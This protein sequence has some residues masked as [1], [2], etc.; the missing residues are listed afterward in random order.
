MNNIYTRIL[1]FALLLS[2]SLQANLNLVNGVKKYDSFSIQYVYDENKTL[3]I[4]DIVIQKNMQEIPNQFTKGYKYG[5]AWFKIELTNKSKNEEF[6]LYFTESIWS[7]IDLY[8]QTDTGWRI[9]QNGLNIPLEKRTIKDSSPA[10][11]LHIPKDETLTLYIKGET[12]ASQIGQFK[13]FTQEEYFNPSRLRLTDLYTIYA[14]ILFAFILLNLYNFVMTRE[15]IYGL[16]VVY[17]GTYI[18]FISM[19]SGIYINFGFPN[20]TEGLHTLGQ[21]TLLALILFSS[22]FLE[23]KKTYPTMQRLFNYLAVGALIFAIML[24]QNIPYA[25][26]ASNIF[27]CSA[28]LSIVVVAILVLKR[29]FKGA[30]YYL[31]ALMLY[32]PSMTLMA[33]N[34]NAMVANTDITRYSFLAGAFLEI[35]L[36][37]LILTNR[38]KYISKLNGSLKEKTQ[39]L[40]ITQKKLQEESITDFLTGIYNRRHFSKLCQEVISR[41][42]MSENLVSF[43]IL[44]IDYFKKYNDTYGHYSGDKILRQVAQ[45]IQESLQRSNDYC[46]RLGGEEFGVIFETKTQ[47]QALQLAHKLRQKIETLEIEHKESSVSPYVTI[48]LGIICKPAQNIKG[49]FELYKEADDLLYKAKENGRNQVCFD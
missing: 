36:F 45:T 32:L 14:A 1:L 15:Y 16:Y 30:Q 40:Q 11:E 18:I 12:I 33:M 17:I 9:E 44:D 37:T 38:Y 25:T 29:G 6:V 2:T 4:D 27:F 28:L 39:Q 48:S 46:F 19:H 5:N 24:S 43:I 20:W 8:I 35:F 47:K 22:E 49:E 26:L 21:L 41:A 34:F 13:I 3:N 7:Q 10:F 23:L 42:K 31:I